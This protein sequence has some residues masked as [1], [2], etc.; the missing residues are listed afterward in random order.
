M[1]L[2]PYKKRE[3]VFLLLFSFDMGQEVP[4]SDIVE[5]VKNEC[6]VAKKYVLEAMARAE[7]ILKAREECDKLISSVCKDYRIA[8]IQSVERN[9]VRLAIFEA[10]I[11][12]KL[13]PKVVF[14]E[15]KRLAKKFATE[16]AANFVHALLA[17]A[18]THT[19]VSVEGEAPNLE[20][21]YQKLETV[22]SEAIPK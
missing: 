6:K 2:D 22:S 3:L 11:E 8:R 17:A 9:I 1:T 13:P 7:T 12:G 16:E 5:L 15:A 10:L 19:G 4:S 14:A 20:E 21:A 18:S